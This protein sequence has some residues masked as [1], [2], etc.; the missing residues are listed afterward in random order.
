VNEPAA[1]KFSGIQTTFV[2]FGSSRAIANLAGVLVARSIGAAN[3][4]RCFAGHSNSSNTGEKAMSRHFS[5]VTGLFALIGAV[6]STVHAAGNSN[7]TVT[8]YNSPECDSA[9]AQNPGHRPASTGPQATYV[10]RG[11][12][13]VPPPR[14]RQ[15]SRPASVNVPV[16]STVTAKVNFLG[17]AQGF[18]M[19]KLGNAIL[20]C[21]VLD[22]AANEVSFVVPD[23]GLAQ[24]TAA[25]LQVVRP[26]GT[27]VKTY[28]IQLIS[29]PELIVEQDPAPSPAPG[30]TAP[31]QIA[32]T[33]GLVL[34][35]V[36]SSGQLTSGSA[37]GE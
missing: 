35:T 7:H 23:M 31:E 33:S 18:V 15:P 5:I 28:A 27:I 19:L 9:A 29:K 12:T 6:S 20:E 24:A 30:Q 10:A 11:F 32:T 8:I 4:N 36:T 21:R 22:W 2:F 25:E 13:R 17:D 16:G 3:G 14:L 26:T 1:V 37:N 34:G